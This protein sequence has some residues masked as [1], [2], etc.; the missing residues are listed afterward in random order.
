MLEHEEWICP[1]CGKR[2]AD[3]FCENCGTPRPVTPQP[4]PSG[5]QAAP[6]MPGVSDLMGAAPEQP[7][8]AAGPMP[9]QPFS[10]A[11]QVPGET[12]KMPGVSDLMGAAPEPPTGAAGP[13]SSQPFSGADQ[14]SDETQ[15]M[16]RVTEPMGAAPEPPTGAAGPMSSQPFSGVDQVSDDTQVMPRVAEP[17][18]AAPGQ[19]FGPAGQMTP[20][21][22]RP[23]PAQVPPMGPPQTPP[24]GPAQ[25]PPSKNNRTVKILSGVAIVLLLAVIGVFAYI[26]GAEGRYEKKAMEAEQVTMDARNLVLDIKSLQGTPDSDQDKDF[27]DRV[28]KAKGNLDQLSGSLKSMRTGSKYQSV[29]KDLVEAVMLETTVLDDVHTVLAD[30]TGG[31]APKAVARVK[32]H[33]AELKDRGAKI[34]IGAAD[35][36]QPMDLTGLD[37]QLTGYIQKRKAAEAAAKAKAAAEAAA[38]AK[39]EAEARAK[40]LQQKKAKR[41]QEELN[42]ADSVDYIATDLQLVGHQAKLSGYFL[43][44]TPH[45]IMSIDS[46]GLEIK[47]Y[48]DGEIVYD[49][50]GQLGKQ[51]MNGWLYP[52]QR[53]NAA[54]N[55]FLDDEIPDFDDF[56]VY[57]SNTYW[58]YHQN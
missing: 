37:Q 46:S 35:F 15:R 32:D 43:N 58:T 23:T 54:L 29:N 7:T 19:T 50:A 45:P 12:Q 53:R 8:G 16:P 27:I 40:A 13:M 30:P 38:K 55:V 24:M 48:K 1:N 57:M 31:D 21:P 3:R 51:V 39:A 41:V 22:V 44:K 9:T 26:S 11:E 25:A 34:Q 20:Q 36:T 49:W 56:R 33:V 6:G 47:L 18:G 52:N 2:N 4:A 17:M 14:A 28:E 10:G 42:A 5:E